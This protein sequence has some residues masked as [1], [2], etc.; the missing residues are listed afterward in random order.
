MT[1]RNRELEAAIRANPDEPSAYRVYADWLEEGGDP[2]AP[3]IAVSLARTE[4]DDAALAK[5]ERRLL[6]AL[7]ERG[8][9]EVELRSG[10]VRV[11]EVT[12]G[13]VLAHPWMAF[14][15]RLLVRSASAPDAA[16]EI[17]KIGS[18]SLRTLAFWSPR[19][20]APPKDPMTAALVRKLWKSCPRLE[21]I[22]ARDQIL[23]R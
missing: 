4:R 19:G 17:A 11:A 22:E 10:F 20:V 9:T 16:S 8:I 18:K 14:A 7:N 5:E 23:E 1:P 12:D 3:L 13:A 2:I 15:E 6:A 21:R